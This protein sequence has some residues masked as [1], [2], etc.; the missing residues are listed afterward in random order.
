MPNITLQIPTEIEEI[1][2]KHPEI[3]WERIVT[4]SLWNYAKKLRLIDKVTSKSK[5]SDRDV[6]K[7]DRTIKVDLSKH[8]KRT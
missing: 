4:D 2:S 5:L 3:K 6:D 7:L 1:L 8:Y